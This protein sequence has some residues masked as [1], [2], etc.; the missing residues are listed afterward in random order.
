MSKTTFSITVS[1]ILAAFLFVPF[2][3]AD[4]LSVNSGGGKNILVNPDAYID[5][6]FFGIPPP[7]GPGGTFIYPGEF[8]F[9]IIPR[10]FQ[11]LINPGR[12]YEESITV[13]NATKYDVVVAEFVCTR[14]NSCNW[15]KF[16]IGGVPSEERS[17]RFLVNER[18]NKSVDFVVDIPIEAEYLEYEFNISFS[19]AG[20]DIIRQSNYVLGKPSIFQFEEWY[21]TVIA[22][23]ILVAHVFWIAVFLGISIP[24]LF[25]RR[26]KNKKDQKQSEYNSDEDDDVEAE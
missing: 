15:A 26:R 12:E 16:L 6:F 19:S 25:Y 20:G 24:F 22:G 3:Q 2:V 8:D 5:S 23:G 4:I 21:N 10:F 13:F 1:V 18:L 11:R 17:Y 14:D 7:T 9:F